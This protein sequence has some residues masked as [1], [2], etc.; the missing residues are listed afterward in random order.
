VSSPLTDA[1]RTLG[2]KLAPPAQNL[3]DESPN[4]ASDSFVKKLLKIVTLMAGGGGIIWL[5][6]F[7]PNFDKYN[8]L[9]LVGVWVV[10]RFVLFPPKIFATRKRRM[11]IPE[12]HFLLAGDRQGFM[13]RLWVDAKTVVID[14]SN[15]YHFGHNNG[16]DAQ[17]LGL[18]AAQL[19]NEG[20]RVVCF[21]DASIYY[22]LR[23][24]G[25]FSEST[26]HKLP[27][28]MDIF[29]LNENEIYVVPSGTQADKYVLS[30][31]RHLP[32]AFAVTND[33]FRDYAKQF[34][35]VMKGDQWRKSV[36][37]SKNELRL[38]KHKFK[39]PVYF[40]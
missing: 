13:P 36:M 4:R 23:E 39:T 37:I 26:R 27:L 1:P 31:L 9:A 24:H 17:P 2:E 18:I 20:Y 5:F 3:T 33:Q 32:K 12:P 14:G 22:T 28:L 30:S 8:L 19:R 10:L 16:L 15:I 6:L 7:V 38:V 35:D 34:G 29:G 11:R 21:F 25:A 40:S